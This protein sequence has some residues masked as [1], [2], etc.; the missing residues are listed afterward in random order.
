MDTLPD[1]AI[2]IRQPWA[3]SILHAGKDIENRSW[4]TRLRGRVCVHAAK[5]MTRDEWEDGLQTVHQ[6]SRTHP[7]PTG[8]TM[9]AFEDLARGQIV[10]TVEIVGCVTDSASPWFFGPYGF[11]LQKPIVLGEPIPLRGALGFF[12]WRDNICAA[13]T[14]SGPKQGMLL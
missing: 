2:S 10:G 8:L 1:L 13:P 11:V 6:I 14:P 7:F 9:P 3:W 5:G 12:K 4:P